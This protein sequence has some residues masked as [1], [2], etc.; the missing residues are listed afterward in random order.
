M[1]DN[2]KNPFP[3][4][5][6]WL[7]EYW[8]DVHASM[9]VYARD[10]L[11]GELPDE[12]T[13]AVDERL[14]IDVDEEVPRNYLPD[15]AISE[16]WDGSLGQPLGPGGVAVEAAEPTIVDVGEIKL[17]R[18]EITDSRGHIVTV[19]EFLSPTNKIT[20][21]S[22]MLWKRKRRETLGAGI[23]WVE[24]DLLREGGWA[25]PDYDELLTLPASG[26]F[27]AACAIRARCVRQH[28]F[29]LF[30]L[31]KKLPAIRIPLRPNDRDVALDLQVLIDQCYERGRYG[32]KINYSEGL[33]PA[34]SAEDLEWSRALLEAR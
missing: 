22:R 13:A 6:P 21:E 26:T 7:E 31:Q 25:L 15:V 5:N 30:P 8:R 12:L 17:R 1:A 32:R 18:L 19:I 9:L 16:S 14:K 20:L 34:L 4:M 27:Y 28:E 2:V 33:R 10:Q 29:Y 11:N 23:N 24:I 3:G